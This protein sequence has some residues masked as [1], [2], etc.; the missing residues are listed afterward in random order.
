MKILKVII[1]AIVLIGGAVGVLANMSNTVLDTMLMT[2]KILK[3]GI[4]MD[5]PAGFFGTWRVKSSMKM[6]NA[7]STF[8]SKGVDMWNLSRNGDVINLYNPNTGASANVNI[9]SVS[10]NVIIFTKEEKYDNK[11]IKDTVTLRLNGNTF[12]GLDEITLETFSLID[13][14][15]IKSEHA[16]YDLKGTKVAG[17]S[18][19]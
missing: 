10:G 6:S 14:S 18:V 5:V 11:K 7:Y 8:K 1:L 4:S 17:V 9:K 13:N 15:L 16:K 3:S 19:E 2:E 12:T